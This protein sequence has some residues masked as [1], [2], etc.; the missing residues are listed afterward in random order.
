MRY[1]CVSFASC[2]ERCTC[3]PPG[4]VAGQRGRPRD[5]RHLAVRAVRQ[6]A[7]RAGA[8]R[9][10]A[11]LLPQGDLR[12]VARPGGGRGRQQPHLPAGGARHQVRRVPVRQG[13]YERRAGGRSV[14]GGRW[15]T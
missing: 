6:G 8:Q 1:A 14:A 10:V 5:G 4:V 11:A 15:R 13:A 3:V 7:G 12:A 2:C 9:A